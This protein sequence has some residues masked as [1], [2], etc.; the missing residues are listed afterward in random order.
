VASFFVSH[1]PSE[2]D[3]G[4]MEVEGPEHI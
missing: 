4:T 1:H 3:D 2:D